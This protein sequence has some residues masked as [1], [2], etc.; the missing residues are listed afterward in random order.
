MQ[1]KDSPEAVNDCTSSN[2]NGVIALTDPKN[3]W[4]AKWQRLDLY[5]PGHYAVQVHGQL[6]EDVL[7][8]L[9]ARGIKYIPRDGSKEDEVAER[10]D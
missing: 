9:T 7:S 10:E 2:F 1:F 4:V 5:A 3:S 8:E 6:P